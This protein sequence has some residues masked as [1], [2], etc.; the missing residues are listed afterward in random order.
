MTGC[1]SVV[2]DN[3]CSFVKRA[4]GCVR[5]RAV[6]Q[7]GLVAGAIDVVVGKDVRE[8]SEGRPDR[9]EDGGLVAELLANDGRLKEKHLTSFGIIDFNTVNKLANFNSISKF[10]SNLNKLYCFN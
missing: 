2:T 10:V 6:I 4:I 5:V 3:S 8:V 9:P 7:V 1:A